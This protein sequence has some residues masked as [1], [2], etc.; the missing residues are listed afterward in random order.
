MASFPKLVWSVVGFAVFTVGAYFLFQDNR[1]FDVIF[2]KDDFGNKMKYAVEGARDRV[3]GLAAPI[4][5]PV[6]NEGKKII[7][8]FYDKA[9]DEVVSTVGKAKEE[10]VGSVKKSVN[11]KIDDVAKDISFS[12]GTGSGAAVTG[13][14]S[15]LGFS[16]KSGVPAIF[17]L[18]N[19]EGA[20]SVATFSISW[21]D[22]KK[23][24]V[25]V[26]DGVAKTVYHIWDKTGEYV[27]DVSF[28]AGNTKRLFRGYI[29]VY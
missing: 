29:V 7:V 21:G 11:E 12:G 26:A 9:K 28:V 25:I 6:L 10:V 2:P 5:E 18:K 3:Y 1:V 14:D 16:V 8:S 27:L 23:E 20:N 17:I 4:V 15:L 13:G 22:G 24:S 19:S